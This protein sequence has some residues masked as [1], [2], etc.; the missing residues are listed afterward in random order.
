MKNQLERITEILED[1]PMT[2][3]EITASF[4]RSEP[5]VRAL[6][7]RGIRLELFRKG[8]KTPSGGVLYHLL[9]GEIPEDEEIEDFDFV[10]PCRNCGCEWIARFGCTDASRVI[11]TWHTKSCSCSGCGCFMRLSDAVGAAEILKSFQARTGKFHETPILAYV[12]HI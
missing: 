3:A 6:M 2:I 10:V 9:D 1:R 7:N 4:D 11:E 12:G 8:K 5:T